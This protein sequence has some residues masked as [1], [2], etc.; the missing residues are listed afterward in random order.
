MADII[1]V[2]GWALSLAL[3][4]TGYWGWLKYRKCS[5]FNHQERERHESLL[6]NLERHFIEEHEKRIEMERLFQ[7]AR[8][9]LEQKDV[10]NTVETAIINNILEKELN[11]R[12]LLEAKLMQAQKM[13][14][15]GQ[16]AAGVAHEINNPIG[17]VMSNLNTL[18]DYIAIIK[19]LLTAYSEMTSTLKQERKQENTLE[20]SS[21]LLDSLK[22]IEA[23]EQKEDMAFILTDLDALLTESQEGNA[24]VQ[25]IV[26]NLKS[27]AR[28]D[29]SVKK[30]VDIH[31]GLESTLKMV[32]N[33]VKYKCVIQK[34]YGDIPHVMCNPGQLNQV[35]INL[36]VNAAHAIE[37][38]GVITIETSNTPTHAVI[39][40]SD[41]GHGIP[42]ELLDKIFDPFFTTKPVGKG[43][44]LGL[45]IS[46]GI[47]QDHMGSID[48][49]S[50]VGKGTCFTLQLPLMP[51]QSGQNEMILYTE[52]DFVMD[53]KPD[54]GSESITAIL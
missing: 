32:W 50:E 52:Q 25:E 48:V 8:H 9:Q 42:E 43:S 16:L 27:F 6:K 17:F 19:E 33:E 44:G 2:I 4:A 18:R 1:L 46:Y 28:L 53:E 13:E 29:E 24:R 34:Q 37:D 21:R 51:P 49:Q 22:A 5:Q 12:K 47:I 41:T 10:D 15:I 40:I 20:T 31:E 35:F 7:K 38:H 39:K 3:A 54:A 26:R 23:V 45:S 36:I 30:E 11:E 14:S